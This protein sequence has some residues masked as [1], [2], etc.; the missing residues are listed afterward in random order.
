VE[1]ARD[2]D[3][4]IHDAQYMLADM[5]GKAGWGH[6]V[7]EEAVRLNTAWRAKRLALYS[8]DHTRTD[9]NI[10]AVEAHCQELVGIAQ[11][12]LELFAAAEGMSIA[13]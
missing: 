3:L 11:A 8:H 4:V 5:P 10:A 1:F 6:L 7:A 13:L 12:D 9:D 2:A